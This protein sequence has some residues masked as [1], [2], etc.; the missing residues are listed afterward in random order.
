VSALSDS[1]MCRLCEMSSN[2]KWHY[3]SKM[4]VEGIS[5]FALTM[6][7]SLSDVKPHANVRVLIC[8]RV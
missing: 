7:L 5:S 2:D 4:I 8:D 6:S 3:T 1:V